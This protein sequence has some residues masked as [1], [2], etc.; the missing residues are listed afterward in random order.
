MG[1]KY[2]TFED[3]LDAIRLGLYEETKNMT[4]EERA[5]YI[6]AMAEP[7]I[8]EYGLKTVTYE[9]MMAMQQAEREKEA[10]LAY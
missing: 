5:A 8:K 7:V 1:M 3:E 9:Q 2:E 4:H 6:N 10:A